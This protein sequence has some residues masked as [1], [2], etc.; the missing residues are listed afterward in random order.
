MIARIRGT[1]CAADPERALV[2]LQPEGIG[3]V[4]RVS[5]SQSLLNR[6]QVDGFVAVPTP[7]HPGDNGPEGLGV[8]V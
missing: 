3:V 1:I 2:E 7:L 4:L 5:V 8:C 6:V